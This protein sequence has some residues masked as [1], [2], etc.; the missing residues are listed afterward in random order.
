MTMRKLLRRSACALFVF[1]VLCAPGIAQDQRLQDRASNNGG[2][3]ASDSVPPDFVIGADDVL[4]IVFW[5]ETAMSSEVVVRPDG[6]IS[7]PLLKDVQAAGY[8]PEQLTAT[9]VKAASKYVAQPNATVIV[10]QIHSRKVFI[11]GQVAKPGSFPLTGD[12]TVLQLIS[13]AGDVLE[14]AKSKDIVVV[15]KENG[16]E[17][18]SKFNYKDVLKGKHIE[19]NILLRPGD[20]VIVP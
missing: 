11:V 20:T 2:P 14:Y 19:Q 3:I 4:S 1:V 8:T 15:S 5:Q 7:L 13:L 18:R 6:K 16:S 17:H 12:M 10:K 9:L